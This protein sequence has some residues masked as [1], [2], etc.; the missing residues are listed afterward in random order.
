[1]AE[2]RAAV[3]ADVRAAGRRWRRAVLPSPPAVGAARSAAT[4]RRR[5]RWRDRHAVD[6]P[7]PAAAEAQGT[8]G[9]RA[10]RRV[11]RLLRVDPDGSRGQAGRRRRAGDVVAVVQ[12]RVAVVVRRQVGGDQRRRRRR[13]RHDPAAQQRRRVVDLAEVRGHRRRERRDQH[14][15]APVDRAVAPRSRRLLPAHADRQQDGERQ[16]QHAA[17][18]ADPDREVDARAGGGGGGARRGRRRRRAAVAL[19]RAVST[20]AAAVADARRRDARPVGVAPELAA[21]VVLRAVRPAVAA[22]AV[23]AARAA[24]GLVRRVLA[25]RVAVAAPRRRHAVAVAARELVRPARR[26]LRARPS[27]AGEHQPDRARAPPP[28]DRRRGTRVAAAAEGHAQVAAVA[29]VAAARAAP[30]FRR[31]ETAH[32]HDVGQTRRG[33][34]RLSGDQPLP[35]A[36]RCLVHPLKRRLGRRPVGPVEMAAEHAQPGRKPQAAIVDHDTPVAAVEVTGLDPSEVE[37]GPVDVPQGGVDGDRAETAEAELEER[38]ARR[39]VRGGALDSRGRLAEGRPEQQPAQS[40]V[41]SE[42]V[43]SIR[44]QSMLDS[45]THTHAR[46]AVYCGHCL[47][48]LL[49]PW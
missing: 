34:R 1:V 6:E 4:L 25:V 45:R 16:H 40:T 46:T 24:V 21:I 32:D 11:Q 23:A 48:Q 35:T 26:R 13:R 5:W 38:G 47:K 22:R 31:V 9:G 30:Q 7:T 8:L 36:A 20:V 27:V 41:T 10:R 17:D 43:Y 49:R 18:D 3:V 14:D 33:R 42:I 28:T 19:V 29:V 37:I 2:A 44:Q 39:A 12:R 15:V